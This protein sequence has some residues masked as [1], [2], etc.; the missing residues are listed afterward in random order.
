M[1][2]ITI[3]LADDHTVVR[4]GLR[5]FL[6]MQP[7]LKVVAE[8][9]DGKQAVQLAREL[10][11]DVVLLD[12]SMPVL[13]GLEA[14]RQICMAN[15]DAHIIILSSH[16]D[17]E[18]VEE[19]TKAGAIGYLLKQTPPQ[20]LVSAIHAAHAGH[21][22]FSPTITRRMT[23]NIRRA[24]ISGKAVTRASDDLTA[25]ELQVLQLVADGYTNKAM[26]EQLEISVKT[27]EKHRQQLMERLR[28]HDIAGLTR[29][30]VA[31]GI[32]GPQAAERGA[33]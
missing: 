18:Y 32:G 15:P 10:K 30:A 5:A 25:R 11:P 1:P 28:I 9:A 17:D 23:D 26:A 12:I 29:Y 20:D 6:N 33:E 27:I 2:D 7:G 3:L 22:A 8:A 21:A 24:F 14:T 16:D 4:E 19:L 13:N 31:R